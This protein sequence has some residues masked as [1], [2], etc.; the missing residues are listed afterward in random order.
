MGFKQRTTW[1]VCIWIVR[2]EGRQAME[3][4]G[5]RLETGQLGDGNRW[6]MKDGPKAGPEGIEKDWEVASMR[7]G[8]HLGAKGM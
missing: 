6:E 3:Q 7:P 8:D 4:R 5:M 2:S 1:A